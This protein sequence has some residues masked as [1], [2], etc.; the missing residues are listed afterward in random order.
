MRRVLSRSNGKFKAAAANFTTLPQLVWNSWL[1]LFS[2]I[3]HSNSVWQ[4]LFFTFLLLAALL[5]LLLLLLLISFY[6]SLFFFFLCLLLF[7]F[8][9]FLIQNLVLNFFHKLIT[10]VQLSAFTLTANECHQLHQVHQ[11]P[12][13]FIFRSSIQ[14]DFNFRIFSFLWF[15]FCKMPSMGEEVINSHFCPGFP[16][17]YHNF[18]PEGHKW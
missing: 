8:I 17:F 2:Q 12:E 9:L 5:L 1:N 14:A 10:P 16:L 18:C 4:Q 11:L 15:M 3:N 6:F 13:I 7:T